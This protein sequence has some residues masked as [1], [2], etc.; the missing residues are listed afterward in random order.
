MKCNE[1]KLQQAKIGL[2]GHIGV[3]HIHSH[4]GF[5]QDDSMGFAMLVRILQECK[6]FD[7]TIKYINIVDNNIEVQL[8][9]GGIGRANVTRGICSCDKQLLRRAEQKSFLSPEF[10]STFLFG[11]NYGQGVSEVATAVSCAY[12]KSILDC[13]KN[14]WVETLYFQDNIPQS[15][16]EFLGGN[17]CIN[18]TVVAWMLTINTTAGGLAP[19]EDSE[20]NIP[21]GNKGILMK[22]LG[23]DTL[24]TIIF[25]SKAYIPSLKN[26]ITSNCF[27]IRW[28][29]ESDNSI[30]G[31]A[32]I[33]AVSSLQVPYIYS[34]TA[35]PRNDN[36][37]ENEVNRVADKIIALGEQYKKS[38][39]SSERI[40]LAHDLVLVA[41]EELGGSIFMSNEIFK[42]FA[43]GGL[44]PGVSAVLSCCT[45]YT[46][47]QRDKQIIYTKE[48]IDLL[49]D[50]IPKAIEY[51]INHYDLALAEINAK[52]INYTPENLLQIII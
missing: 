29:K 48:E 34:D 10:L 22:K 3:G 9:N 14:T 41:S 46:S 8:Q 16:G 28:N 6:P 31:K 24:P 44:L 15:A 4:S 32:L 51:I 7:T 1:L 42:L 26:S 37:L 11:K 45:S 36:S 40:K 35:Y 17:L 2:V 20:G 23:L 50:I 18:D 25:E 49:I 27:N 21:I 12:A 33:E 38:K 47:L 43:G 39:T 5:V 13:I 30:V 19:N 52:K